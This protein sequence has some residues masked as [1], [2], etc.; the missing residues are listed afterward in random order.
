VIG[1]VTLLQEKQGALVLLRLL[2]KRSHFANGGKA[3][4]K[5][6]CESAMS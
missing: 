4:K 1:K 5:N 6:A 2:T 3:D